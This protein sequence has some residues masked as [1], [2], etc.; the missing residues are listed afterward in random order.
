M[1][2]KVKNPL[3]NAALELFGLDP[4]RVQNISISPGIR[5]M[6]V[7]VTLVPTFPEC[8]RCGG[9]YIVVYNYTPRA[10]NEHRIKLEGEGVT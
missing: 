4:S 7:E 8:P 5:H 1:A 6:L 2:V 9:P 10:I 3:E